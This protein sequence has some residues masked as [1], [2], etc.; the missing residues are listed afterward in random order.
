MIAEEWQ[1]MILEPISDRTGLYA[2]IDLE[3]VQDSVLVQYVVKL[4]CINP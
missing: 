4:A 3:P 1:Y 2:V